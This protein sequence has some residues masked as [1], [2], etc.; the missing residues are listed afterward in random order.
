M[1]L[2]REFIIKAEK[3]K[4]FKK[5]LGDTEIIIDTRWSEMETDYCTQD[6]IIVE[7]PIISDRWNPYGLS[8]GDKVYCHH[9]LCDAEN[10]ID[11]NGEKHY[12]LIF[13]DIYCIVKPDGEMVMVSDY[14]FCDPIYDNEDGF[15][16]ERDEKTGVTIQ[17]TVSGIVTNTNV[18]ADTKKARI[19]HLS[20]EAKSLGLSV[21]DI[22]I[23][24][25]DC[26][27]EIKIEGRIYY[28][29]RTKDLLAYES[30]KQEESVC[31]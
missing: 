13:S 3:H 29:V 25:K 8:K 5:K 24:R 18:K 22:I 28:R 16:Y 31:G 21:G 1:K 4:H 11:V 23:Y 9:F 17:K 15:V 30:H 2:L 6:G 26:D 7:T 12:K 14:N 27:Y 20:N 19:A 10:E